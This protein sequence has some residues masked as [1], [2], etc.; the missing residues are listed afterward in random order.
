MAFSVL[1]GD[2]T[3]IEM[4]P[5]RLSSAKQVNAHEICRL[6]CTAKELP[7]GQAQPFATGSFRPEAV[8]QQ[9]Y[10]LDRFSL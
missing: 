2:A 10:L 3:H 1:V 7:N 9:L 4:N 8:A 5:S 6:G